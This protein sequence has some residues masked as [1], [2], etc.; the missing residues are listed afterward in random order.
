MRR[1]ERVVAPQLRE[2]QE[3]KNVRLALDTEIAT[4]C[5]LLEGEE[6]RLESGTQ[7]RS[8]HTK[9]GNGYSGGPS[10]AHWGGLRSPGL[11]D[12]L[13]SFQAGFWGEPPVP[14]VE[15]ASP[16]L[17]LRRGW[18]PTMGSWC[19]SRLWLLPASPLLRLP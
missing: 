16:R 11:T 13:S 14:P 3:R 7:N 8:L 5:K 17:R 12:S 6:S 2:S 9:T 10:S 15:S 4:C 1:A 18:R 19:W